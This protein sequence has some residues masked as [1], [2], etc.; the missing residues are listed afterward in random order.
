MNKRPHES[1]DSDD[2][3]SDVPNKSDK[4]EMDKI[5]Y[6]SARGTLIEI[7]WYLPM[8]KTRINNW[9]ST[10]PYVVNQSPDTVHK[11]LDR[12]AMPISDELGSIPH[13][14]KLFY[15]E[16]LVSDTLVEL[17]DTKFTNNDSIRLSVVVDD[18][19]DDTFCADV[20]K[21]K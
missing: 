19:Y 1:L 8:F 10:N 5:F 7:P 13:T 17:K 15:Q 11:Y 18:N 4:L 16:V 3:P 2:K 20:S 14:I 9:S 21:K 6:I 12:F